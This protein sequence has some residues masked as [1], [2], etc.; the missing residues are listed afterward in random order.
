MYLLATNIWLE[1][2]LDQEKAADVKSFFERFNED[3][4][5]TDFSR[6]SIGILLFRLKRETVLKDF[7][8]DVLVDGGIRIVNLKMN[9][10]PRLLE[11]RNL[12][13]MDFDDSYQYTIA[14]KESKIR[15][16][17]Y[18]NHWTIILL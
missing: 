3:L 13:A 7:V 17:F 9:D 16:D 18:G 2:L 6:F 14:L 8:Q 12:F 10:F 1:L 11:I 5:I 4:Y 15:N